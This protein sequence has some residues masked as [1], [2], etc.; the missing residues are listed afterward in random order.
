MCCVEGARFELLLLIAYSGYFGTSIVYI[1]DGSSASW[2]TAVLSVA[3]SGV[4]ATSLP[5]QGL[6]FFAG[7]RTVKSSGMIGL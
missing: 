4:A 6:A 5:N 7:G 2:S 3:R 1:F